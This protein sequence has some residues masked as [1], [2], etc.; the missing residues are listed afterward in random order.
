MHAVHRVREVRIMLLG[1]VQSGTHSFLAESHGHRF[2]RTE[3]W[4]LLQRSQ[5]PHEG[6]YSAHQYMYIHARMLHM[7][8]TVCILLFI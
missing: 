1:F 7:Y 8:T 3:V 5:A 6:T 2:G 4:D